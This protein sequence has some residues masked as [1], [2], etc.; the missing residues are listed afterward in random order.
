M[1]NS[2]VVNAR[3]GSTL[4]GGRVV[5]LNPTSGS[6]DH[7]DQVRLLASEHG[8]DVRETQGEGDAVEFAAEAAEAGA[9]L[10]AAAGGDGTVNEVVRGI[11]R[12]DA[13]DDVTLGVVPAGT[14]NNFSQNVGV[15][16]IEHAF[17][18]LD[19]GETRR[20]D[21][22]VAGDRPFVNSC[23]GGLTADASE[24]TDSELKANFGVLA[25]VL[26]TLREAVDF[27]GLELRVEPREDAKS[28]ADA[29][30]E[31]VVGSGWSGEA[32]LVL[33]GNARRFPAEGRTQADVEDGLLDVTIVERRPAVDLA[34]QTAVHRLLGTETE[35]ITRL[36]A[37]SLELRARQGEPISYSLDGEMTAAERLVVETRPRTL[38]LRVGEAYEP[39][40]DA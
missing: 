10:V 36:K 21:L 32:L 16:S 1:A 22:G 35:N 19:D 34:G 25:Y 40:P 7:A 13:F 20:I 3:E 30:S 6:G 9:E 14:G 29:E 38:S 24:T 31:E 37:P 33:V 28:E 4:D 5:V 26:N 23:V 2:L 8:F 17:S 15:E 12:A 18:V 11:W 39:H 27:D